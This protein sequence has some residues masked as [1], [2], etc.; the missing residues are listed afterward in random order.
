MGHMEEI[1]EGGAIL[2][3]LAFTK[4]M[5]VALDSLNRL[6]IWDSVPSQKNKVLWDIDEN[7]DD[8]DY[9]NPG[10]YS[11]DRPLKCK[12]FEDQGYEVDDFETGGKALIIKVKDSN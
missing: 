2:K 4:C 6:W 8:E 3:K 10:D 12:Y 7:Y 9:D 1:C 5:S 11:V